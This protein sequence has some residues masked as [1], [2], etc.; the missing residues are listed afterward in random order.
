[1]NCLVQTPSCLLNL[2]IYSTEVSHSAGLW[3]GRSTVLAVFDLDTVTIVVFK[4]VSL[5]DVGLLFLAMVN[6]FTEI[7]AFYFENTWY[8]KQNAFCVVLK[9]KKVSNILLNV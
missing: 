6:D 2:L 4:P 9:K 3:N 7:W 1:M 8:C 5:S